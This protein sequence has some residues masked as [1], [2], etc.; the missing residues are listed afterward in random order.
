MN[1]AHVRK[2]AVGQL[3]GATMQI[4]LAIIR[5]ALWPLIVLLGIL[6]LRS[7]LAELPGRLT[8]LKAGSVE[9]Q[10]KER[11][12]RQ[13]FAPEQRAAFKNL[14]SDEVE[15]FLLISFSESHAFSYKVDIPAPTYRQRMLRLQAAGLLTLLNPDDPGTNLIHNLTPLGKRVR[16]LIVDST[17]GLIRGDA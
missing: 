16:A 9:I 3:L 17:V 1:S 14:S 8:G 15:I 13:G 6:I 11:I 5:Y 2:N 10:F 7:P 4:A 12:E